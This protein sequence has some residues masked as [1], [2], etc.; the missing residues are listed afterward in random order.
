MVIPFTFFVYIN[1]APKGNDANGRFIKSETMAA[2]QQTMILMS[3]IKKICLT[4]FFET[5]KHLKHGRMRLWRNG[6]SIY[7]EKFSFNTLSISLAA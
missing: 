1:G 3:S 4:V 2:V 6:A 7:S 5:N